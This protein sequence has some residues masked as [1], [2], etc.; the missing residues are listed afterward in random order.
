MDNNKTSSQSPLNVKY[1]EFQ[2]ISET[3]RQE[4]REVF[5]RHGIQVQESVPY[6]RM[7]NWEKQ[8]GQRHQLECDWSFTTTL[9]QNLIGQQQSR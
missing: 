4:I 6:L 9:P 1:D 5:S 7:D 2:K 3:V 8:G